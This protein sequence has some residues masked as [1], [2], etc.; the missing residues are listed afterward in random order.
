MSHFDSI[1]MSVTGESALSI[2]FDQCQFTDEGLKHLE[3]FGLPM[4]EV[5]INMTELVTLSDTAFLS[6]AHAESNVT[7]VSRTHEFESEFQL[8]ARGNLAWLDQRIGFA[9]GR[10]GR[11][12]CGGV[13]TN[14][15]DRT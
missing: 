7:I 9:I 2:R 1:N 4:Y 3:K 14:R 15:F 10:N 6:L 13:G 5:E 8:R 12:V 11:S